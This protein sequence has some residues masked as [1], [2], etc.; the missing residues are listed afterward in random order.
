MAFKIS[1]SED[2]Q[3]TAIQTE[4]ASA[5]AELDTAVE[6]MNDALVTAADALT[7]RLA[8]YNDKLEAARAFIADIVSQAEEDFSDKSERWQEGERGEICRAWIDEWEQVNLE[9]VIAP[10]IEPI[11]LDAEDHTELLDQLPREAE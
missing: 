3:L 8:E 11:A 4:L 2:A 9:D 6:D 10:D 1:K 7:D 5:K